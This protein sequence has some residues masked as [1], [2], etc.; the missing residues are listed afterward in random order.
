M[1]HDTRG[2]SVVEILDELLAL[3]DNARSIP[4][5]ASVMINQSEVRDLLQLARDAVPDQVLRADDVLADIDSVRASGRQEAASIIASARQDAENIVAEA[6][7]QASRLVSN[8]AITIAARSTAARI[9][10][11]AK[12]KAERLREGA[13]HYSDSTLANLEGQ[14]NGVAAA[15]EEAVRA[16]HEKMDAAL[17]QIYAGR[18]VLASRQETTDAVFD[19]SEEE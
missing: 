12:Q 6:R 4:M 5:S 19:H 2:E 16:A 3:V 10:D 17:A 1:T 14:V 13:N 9:E 7:A 18:E 11:E 15:L 8:D